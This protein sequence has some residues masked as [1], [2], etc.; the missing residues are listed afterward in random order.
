MIMEQKPVRNSSLQWGR[1]GEG[2]EDETRSQRCLST[3]PLQ[4]G[5]S[6]EGAEDSPPNAIEPF[7][8]LLQWG[9]SG[10][11]AEDPPEVS[12]AA[13]SVMRFNGAA[14][15]KERKTGPQPR[16]CRRHPIASMGP[17]R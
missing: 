2:A 1:S 14:P 3:N 7:R 17:L 9:R 13:S 6:G 16:R 10:E 8:P 12:N 4:W 5:R 15:V 11:G